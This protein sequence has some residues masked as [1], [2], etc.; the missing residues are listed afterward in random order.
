MAA[1]TSAGSPAEADTSGRVSTGAL[2]LNSL[3]ALLLGT[4]ITILLHEIGHW[5]AGALLGSRSF[6]FAFGVTQEPPLSGTALALE[7]LAGP[8]VSL[9]IGGVMQILQPF[10]FKGNFA[11]LL[12]IWTACTSLMATV[13]YLVVTPVAGDTAVA[14][15]ALGLPV[16]VVF[17]A[18]AVGVA[19]MFGVSQLWSVHAVRL[20]GRE[21]SRLRHFSWFPW[22]IAV[23]IQAGMLIVYLALARMQVGPLEQIVLI[24]A[25]MAQTVFGPMSMMFVGRSQE[26]EE[27]LHVKPL[28]W[29]GIA[30]FVALVAFNVA[31]SGGLGLG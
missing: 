7:A 25:G 10:R 4:G 31:I 22:L 11:H 16:W 29:I 1:P 13:T 26:L 24:T 20:C 19:G 27:P 9:V 21:P 12:W 23:P 14:V 18:M 17:V 30:G 3:V 28:P 15:S 6:L 2:L 5:V 8:V